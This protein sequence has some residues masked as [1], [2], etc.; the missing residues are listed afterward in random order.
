[1]QNEQSSFEAHNEAVQRS[2]NEAEV[3]CARVAVRLK[4]EVIELEI[5]KL[6]ARIREK[7]KE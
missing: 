4:P 6:E 7:E 3:H 2:V 5:R 1:M